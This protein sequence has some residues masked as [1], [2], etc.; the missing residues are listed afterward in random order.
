[1][2]H[3]IERYVITLLLYFFPLC[4]S[5]ILIYTR[6]FQHTYYV[7]SSCLMESSPS[8]SSHAAAAGS[9]G[10]PGLGQMFDVKKLLKSFLGIFTSSDSA[11][12]QSAIIPVG[13][14]TSTDISSHN[15]S[16]RI[17]NKNKRKQLI[18]SDDDSRIVNDDSEATVFIENEGIKVFCIVQDGSMK[19]VTLRFERGCFTWGLPGSTQV[20]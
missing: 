11:S 3:L 10:G 9:P 12:K 13:E 4:V 6:V 16:S 20:R 15:T 14:Q 1:M 17:K 5:S 18:I 8:S 2:N 19:S 7:Y